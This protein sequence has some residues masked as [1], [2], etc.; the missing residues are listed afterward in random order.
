MLPREQTSCGARSK[1]LVPSSAATGCVLG[2]SR[3]GGGRGMGKI[4]AYDLEQIPPHLKLVLEQFISERVGKRARRL[5]TSTKTL[6][7][8]CGACGIEVRVDAANVAEGRR[9]HT[10][11]PARCPITRLGRVVFRHDEVASCP[12]P[13]KA[14]A[15]VRVARGHSRRASFEGHEYASRAEFVREHLRLGRAVR[16]DGILAHGLYLARLAEHAVPALAERD[17]RELL[18]STHCPAAR[19]W[20]RPRSTAG[21]GGTGPSH[22]G[23]CAGGRVYDRLRAGTVAQFGFRAQ[24]RG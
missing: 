1:P 16:R 20:S 23:N 9:L 22:W 18:R 14:E 2:D 21:A 8:R 4:G 5:G 12:D 10:C 13:I 7:L 6:L 11:P 24:T 3:R 15:C 19:S 17:A